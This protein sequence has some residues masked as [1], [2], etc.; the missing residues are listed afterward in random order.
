MKIGYYLKENR[1]LLDLKAHNKEEAIKEIALVLKGAE[2][3]DDFDIF[4][5]NVFER[6]KLATTGIGHEIA[7]PHARTD[8]VRDFVVAFGRSVE[9]VDFQSLDGRP[10]KL[11]FLMGTPEKKRLSA[12]LKILAHLSRL[13]EKE[14]FRNSLLK[15]NNPREII[16]IF[17]KIES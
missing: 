14:T 4:L 15:A 17:Q 10:A 16:D 1:I 7:I 11:I 6:E 5:N 13:L 12:Y 9:G 8:T 2:E 3:I